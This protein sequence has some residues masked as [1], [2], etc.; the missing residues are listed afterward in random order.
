[1]DIE[2]KQMEER[3]IFGSYMSCTLND[4]SG[5]LFHPYI[6]GTGGIDEKYKKI[7]NKNYGIDI[8][9]ILFQFYVNPIPYE[10]SHLKEIENYRKKE[11]SIGIPIIINNENFFNKNENERVLFLKN[12]VIQKLDLLRAIIK[13]KKLDTNINQLIIDLEKVLE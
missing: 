5:D 4:I 8:N 6:W 12:S 9:L 2:V 7:K 13:K 11:K 1:M 10:L 3:A